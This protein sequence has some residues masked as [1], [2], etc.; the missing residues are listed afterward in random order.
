MGQQLRYMIF[1]R[2]QA[3]YVTYDITWQS[4]F[5]LVKAYYLV[6]QKGSGRNLC[7]AKIATLLH[8]F[9]V[10]PFQNPFYYYNY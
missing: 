9:H 6:L 7:I 2:K 5:P 10:Q 3:Y 8:G 1:I 4:D